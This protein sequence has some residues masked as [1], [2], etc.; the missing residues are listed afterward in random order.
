MRNQLAAIDF[1]EHR[2][3]EV[4]KKADRTQKYRKLYSKRTK[5]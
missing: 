4:D 1:N 2:E 5:Q 3:R